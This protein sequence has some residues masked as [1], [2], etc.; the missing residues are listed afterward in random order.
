MVGKE[1]RG[2]KREGKR[3]GKDGEGDGLVLG[4]DTRWEEE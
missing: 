1:G 3:R 2:E 4:S